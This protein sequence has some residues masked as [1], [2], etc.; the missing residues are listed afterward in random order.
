MHVLRES[1]G[2]LHCHTLVHAF[3]QLSGEIQYSPPT[4]YLRTETLVRMDVRL[5]NLAPISPDLS[6]PALN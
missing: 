2:M 1:A 4:Y 6:E 5:F 3:N